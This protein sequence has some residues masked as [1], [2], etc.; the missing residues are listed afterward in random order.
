MRMSVHLIALGTKEIK[1]KTPFSDFTL[2]Q[3]RGMLK[4]VALKWSISVPVLPLSR[5]DIQ[6]H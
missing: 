6:P 3:V 2:L 4:I 1:G 5:S